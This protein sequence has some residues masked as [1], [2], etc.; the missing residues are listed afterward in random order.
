MSAPAPLELLIDAD[1][2]HDR[3]AAQAGLTIGRG[4][5]CDIVIAGETV[6]R[7]HARLEDRGGN[8][9]AVCCAP[10]A[11]LR[12]PKGFAEEVVLSAG[13]R[14]TIGDAEFECRPAPV[15]RGGDEATPACGPT[16]C[17]YCGKAAKGVRVP[18]EP[19]TAALFDRLAMPADSPLA[20]AGRSW[21]G[22]PLV[23]YRW[24]RGGHALPVELDAAAAWYAFFFRVAGAG[25]P[26]ADHFEPAPR[27]GLTVNAQRTAAVTRGWPDYHADRDR[28]VPIPDGGPEDPFAPPAPG[29]SPKCGGCG[30]R[31]LPADVGGGEVRLLPA[32]VGDWTIGG[33]HARGGMGLVLRG[34]DGT[35]T[36][37]A[38][39]KIRSGPEGADRFKREADL[40]TRIDHPHVVRT[41]DAGS[42]GDCD[43]LVLEWIEGQSLKEVMNDHLGESALFPA[44]T[45]ARWGREVAEGLGAVHQHGVHRDVKPSNVL[46][47]WRGRAKIADLGVA[48]A[49]AHPGM[50]TT[51]A[52]AGTAAY[53]APEQLA[54][55]DPDERAD[56]YALGV[57]LYELLTGARPGFG[58]RPA[59]EENATVWADLDAALA[60]LLSPNPDGRPRTA[61]EAADLLGE[62]GGGG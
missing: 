5:G 38:A 35:A 41:L 62:A 13:I 39:I 48:R 32:S 33:F 34:H 37:P 17:P 43:Y 15:P 59:S 16:D 36:T 11:V 4:D 31:V 40:L 1:D 30:R 3:V 28:V 19:P 57:T 8:L 61:R 26:P 21:R 42:D 53:M 27:G 56:L 20:P 6:A 24:D 50:T 7:T 51:G 25:A 55:T 14:F 60:R 29:K 12:T 10:G 46:V 22:E 23:R 54:G 45:A 9:A 18:D 52:V 44:A 49:A 58:S 2:R 47:D